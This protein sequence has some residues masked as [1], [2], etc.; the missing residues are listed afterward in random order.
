MKRREFITLLGGAG[1]AWPVAARAQQPAIAVIG[2]LSALSAASVAH[3]AAAFRSRQRT[4]ADA[5]RRMCN[6]TEQ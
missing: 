5:C 3:Q 1:A 6:R 2:Y 4:N